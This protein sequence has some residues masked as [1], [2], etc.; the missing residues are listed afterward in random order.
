[1][2]GRLDLFFNGGFEMVSFD[3]LQ[4]FRF[5]WGIHFF[6]LTWKQSTKPIYKYRQSGQC[7]VSRTFINLRQ[8]ERKKYFVLSHPRISQNSKRIQYLSCTLIQIQYFTCELIECCCVYP[9]TEYC[10]TQLLYMWNRFSLLKLLDV[11]RQP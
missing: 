7:S 11:E 9:Y 4:L 2:V 10:M 5:V 3:S 6:A 1:M 8:F